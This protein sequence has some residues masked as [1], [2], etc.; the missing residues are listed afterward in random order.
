MIY[1]ASDLLKEQLTNLPET[2]MGYQILEL[3][4]TADFKPNKVTVVNS[5]LIL[6]DD[7]RAS[8]GTIVAM[9]GYDKTMLSAEKTIYL[10][11]LKIKNVVNL[12]KGRALFKEI[13]S[14]ECGRKT[15]GKGAVDSPKRFAREEELFVRISHFANDRRIDF[16]NKCLKKGSFTTTID[17][18]AK[19]IGC[20][21]FADDP[22]DR[23]ALPNNDPIQFAFLILPKT[24]DKLQEG[25]VQPNFGKTGG[26]EEAYFDDGTSKNTYIKRFKYGKESLS[27]IQAKK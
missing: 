23:Y 13:D 11:D 10:T 19:C 5:E 25:I 20:T 8:W 4:P 16:K 15:G 3:E 26:G 18:Y 9:E 14:N 27:D 2:G 1:K 22:I 24:Y 7:Y 21:P 17:D 12:S 6:D